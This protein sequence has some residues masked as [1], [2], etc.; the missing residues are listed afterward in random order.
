M[1]IDINK[2]YA[3]F[4]KYLKAYITRD[5]IDNFI[6]WL[7]TT[8]FKTAPA[9]AKYNLN[10]EGG[11]CQHSTDT[12][13]MLIKLCGATDT[14]K[15]YSKETIAI[16]SLL[17]DIG[18]VG[19]YRKEIKNVKVEGRWTEQE[20]Y[21][22][23]DAVSWDYFGDPAE[24]SLY[25]LSK[26]F[27]LTR[28]EEIAIRFHNGAFGVGSENSAKV[29]HMFS[30]NALSTLLHS[31]E[32]IS[33]YVT[34]SETAATPLYDLSVEIPKEEAAEVKEQVEERKVEDDKQNNTTATEVVDD[35]PF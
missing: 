23:N 25:V 12:F 11:L 28:A 31:A 14:I 1:T 2:N 21:G 32:L 17:H 26:F 5:G 22:Y 24:N 35:C 9:S 16:V 20:V 10:V 19:M 7:D 8:D 34:E 29:S 27:K 33:T 30:I 15:I 18:K 3:E 13:L 4:K 6:T